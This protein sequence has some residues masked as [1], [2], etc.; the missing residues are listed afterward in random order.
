M[1]YRG[2]RAE[3]QETS[4]KATNPKVTINPIVTKNVLA[5]DEFFRINIV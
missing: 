2:S 4:K 1:R 3:E 5:N